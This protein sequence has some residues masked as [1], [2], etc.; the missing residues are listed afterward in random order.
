MSGLRGRL[1]KGFAANGF[2]QIVNLFIQVAGVPLF[3]HYWG[4]DLYGEWLLLST[5]P[6]YLAMS[7]L[8]FATAAANDMTMR[9]AKEDKEGALSVFQGTWLLITALSLMFVLLGFV[10]VTFTPWTS[11]LKFAQLS[12]SQATTVAFVLLLQVIASQQTGLLWAGYRCDGYYARGILAG[13]LQRLAEFGAVATVVMLGGGPLRTAI[14]AL[15]IR[16]VGCAVIWIDLHARVKWLTIGWGRGRL[17][18]VKPLIGPALTFNAFPL[19]HALSLQGTL[20]VVGVLFGPAAATLFA[21]TRT[22]TRVVWQLV[23][24][25]ANTTWV[26]LSTAFGKHD[27]ELA[28]TLH[29]KAFQMAL[30]TGLVGSTGL[31]IAGPWVYR[32]WTHSKIPPNMPLLYLLA[33]LSLVSIMWSTSY[34]VPMAANKHQKQAVVYVAAIGLGL[35][36]SAVGGLTLGLPGVAVGLIA[37][38]LALSSYVLRSALAMVDDTWGEFLAAVVAPPRLGSLVQGKVRRP[39]DV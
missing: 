2:G 12:H 9:V 13:N 33:A 30:W 28:R 24:A 32:V 20:T 16:L 19:G 15:T 17:S 38:E 29:R 6:S 37:G 22:L 3:L 21:T 14:A 31:V 36:F 10:F 27:L 1:L 25:I 5:I 34:V 23:G 8:S 7:D 35:G 18:A 26:E 11:W 39:A 4:K